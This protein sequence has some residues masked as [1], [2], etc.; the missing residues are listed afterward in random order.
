MSISITSL[1]ADDYSIISP[2]SLVQCIDDNGRVDTVKYR[3]LLLDEA[4][5]AVRRQISLATSIRQWILEDET[6]SSSDEEQPVAKN[7]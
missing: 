5:S 4:D 3:R 6:S 7:R 1:L 2:K